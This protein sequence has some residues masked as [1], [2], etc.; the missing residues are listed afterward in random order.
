MI[1]GQIGRYRRRTTHA[2][3]RNRKLDWWEMPPFED[4][5]LFAFDNIF[6]SGLP[7]AWRQRN[8]DV[9]YSTSYSSRVDKEAASIILLVSSTSTR[10]AWLCVYLNIEFHEK[11]EA[12]IPIVATRIKRRKC[13][14]Y[15]CTSPLS[16][17][18]GS[19]GEL[20]VHR[21]IIR[22]SISVYLVYGQASAHIPCR[23]SC[24]PIVCSLALHCMMHTACNQVLRSMTY[25][26]HGHATYDIRHVRRTCRMSH[27]DMSC[28][29][30]TVGWGS[31]VKTI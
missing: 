26:G 18:A 7:R 20:H 5:F 12:T 31:D 30:H 3:H 28:V 14:G 13:L 4:S 16:L 2:R 25:P 21:T 1:G 8:F 6:V 23:Q 29:K 10:Q 11:L 27:V 22:S 15:C 9:I 24:R 19:S 17:L